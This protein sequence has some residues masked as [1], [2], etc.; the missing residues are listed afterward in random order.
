MIEANA[1]EAHRRFG[2]SA[3]IGD[4]HNRPIAGEHRPGPRRVLADQADVDAPARCAA[5]N[6]AGSRVSSTWTPFFCSARSSS[7]V[8]GAVRAPEPDRAS[9]ARGC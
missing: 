7:I 8:R 5:A 2:F 4:D 3:G 1:A 6:S 9:D